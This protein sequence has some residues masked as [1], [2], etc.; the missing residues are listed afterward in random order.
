[1]HRL[2]PAV[3]LVLI[4]FLVAE[5]LPGSAPMTQPFLWPFLLLIYG[6]GA[7][8]IRESVRRL[9]RGWAS[10]LLLGAAYG[11]VEEGLA[12][13]SLFNPSL[14]GA[15]DWG[16]RIFG[17]NGVYAEAAITIHAVWSATV[18]ILF[19]ELLFPESRD[20]PYLGRIGFVLTG[21]WYLLG[22][23]LLAVLTR[24]SI[25]PGYVAPPLLR[26]LAAL[27]AL[28]LVITAL[29][30]L[31][32]NAAHTTVDANAPQPWLVLVVTLIGSLVWHALLAVLWRVEPAF[33]K[34]PLVI[35][36]MVCALAIVALMAWTLRH[37]TAGRGWN[38]RHRLALVSG[39]VISHS[40]V[41][42]TIL[43]KSTVDRVGVGVLGLVLIV[44]LVLLA[45]RV[46]KRVQ[47]MTGAPPPERRVGLSI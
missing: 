4:A 17:V 46:R 29:I 41:G 21:I 18:P 31:S 33:A 9:D 8:F 24:F 25:A 34:G 35:I 43:T 3:V 45:K 16:A 22:V 47:Y 1:M 44:L 23:A 5:L 19:T 39:A 12:L 42:G 6:P 32:R 10:I 27:V 40:V 11:T 14:Y 15:A 2:L 30:I 20:M 37:W 26:A 36:P 28:L 38:D 7:L 13:Q